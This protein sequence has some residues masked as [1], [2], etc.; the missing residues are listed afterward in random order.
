MP[1]ALDWSPEFVQ[2]GCDTKAAPYMNKE[3]LRVFG[4]EKMWRERLWKKGLVK[5]SVMAPRKNPDYVGTEED[6]T[7]IICQ[8]YLYLSAVV[9]HCRPA[10]FVCLEHW[11]HLC[12]CTPRK[13]H[14][15]YRHSL[16]ELDELIC[17][18]ENAISGCSNSRRQRSLLQQNLSSTDSGALTK[19]VKGKQMTLAQLAEEWLLN[20]C[21]IFQLSFSS[22]A[23]ANALKEAQQFLWSGSEMDPVSPIV[24]YNHLSSHSSGGGFGLPGLVSPT[25]SPKIV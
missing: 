13:R 7:C 19:K 20:S 17:M 5:T 6:P 22:N 21:K 1:G 2:I 12:E 24:Y 10:T 8:Q 4:K 14:L 3:L 25:V 15:L 18:P 23:Y 16:A 11:E 9:C